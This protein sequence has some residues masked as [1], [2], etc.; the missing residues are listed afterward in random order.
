MAFR[1]PEKLRRDGIEQVLQLRLR[2]NVAEGDRIEYVLT[3]EVKGTADGRTWASLAEERFSSWDMD[4]VDR[5]ARRLSREYL[6]A[7][8]AAAVRGAG[9]KSPGP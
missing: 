7:L 3:K 9:R 4:Q 6:D 1:T 5:S 2:R 8:S